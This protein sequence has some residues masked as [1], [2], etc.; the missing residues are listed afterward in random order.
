M[1]I[2]GTPVAVDEQNLPTV[3]GQHVTK[4]GQNRRVRHGMFPTRSE[5]LVA[6][7]RSGFPARNPQDSLPTGIGG[8]ADLTLFDLDPISRS[9]YGRPSAGVAATGGTKREVMKCRSDG[10]KDGQ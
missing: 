8:Y 3:L 4:S 6:Q 9:G 10:Q 7:H 5:M 2:V 1:R